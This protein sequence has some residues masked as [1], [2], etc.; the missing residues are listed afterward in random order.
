M[1]K[2]IR[3]TVDWRRYT[4]IERIGDTWMFRGTRVPV[5]AAVTLLADGLGADAVAEAL[6]LPTLRITALLD[7]VECEAMSLVHVES[8]R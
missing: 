4:G 5:V 6:E 1:M 3:G 2:P 7:F 8:D